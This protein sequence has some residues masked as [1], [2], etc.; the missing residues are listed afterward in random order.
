MKQEKNVESLDEKM[1]DLVKQISEYYGKEK[2]EE[3]R[4]RAK[5]LREGKNYIVFYGEEKAKQIKLKQGKSQRGKK[6]ITDEGKKKLRDLHT[7]KKATKETREKISKSLIG[8]KRNLG[9]RYRKN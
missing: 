8:H 2:A 4:L 6:K 3:I 5:E 9:K 1:V 7:G